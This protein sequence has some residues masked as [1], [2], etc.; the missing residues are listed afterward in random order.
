MD[1]ATSHTTLRIIRQE[2][3]CLAAVIK[4]MQHFTR[5]IASGGDAPDLKVFRAML[6]YISEYPERV[7]HP[8]EDHFLFAPLRARTHAVD[9]AIDTLEAQHGKGE[10]MVRELEH[11]LARYELLGE[12]SRQPFCDLVDQY[13]TFYFEH[14]SLEENVVM[15]AAAE[16]L[17]E[18]DWAT[19][20]AAFALNRD[21]LSGVEFG[22]DFD[23]LFTLIASITPAPIGLG[24]EVR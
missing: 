3:N 24:P 10:H 17:S 9:D 4:A 23:K 8:K 11:A 16:H 22:N 5:E 21:P 2:H 19:A 12:A 20:D 14:M 15:P 18:Q 6:L 1:R 13:A 7:H